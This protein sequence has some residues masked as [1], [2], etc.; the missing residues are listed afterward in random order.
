MRQKAAIN[1]V[2]ELA[3]EDPVEVAGW[4]CAVMYRGCVRR[5][6]MPIAVQTSRRPLLQKQVIITLLVSRSIRRHFRRSSPEGEHVCCLGV[7]LRLP[8]IQRNQQRQCMICQ[9]TCCL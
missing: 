3:I 5:A 2:R 8:G 7:H 1:T 4:R 9:I 6:S